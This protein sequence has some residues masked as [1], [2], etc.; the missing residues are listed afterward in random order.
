MRLHIGKPG[1][2]ELFCTLNGQVFCNVYKFATAVIPPAGIAFRIFVR[3]GRSRSRHHGRAHDVLRSDEL[4]ISP[5]PHQLFFDRVPDFRVV[6]LNE[7]CDLIDH[8]IHPFHCRYPN[9]GNLVS[10]YRIESHL[11]EIAQNFLKSR[12]ANSPGGGFDADRIL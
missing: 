5:L 11:Q 2:E 6:F 8:G 4:D 10:V 12:R 7:C 1:S 9:G 3:T